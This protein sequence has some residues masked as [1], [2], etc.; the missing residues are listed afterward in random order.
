MCVYGCRCAFMGVDVC[1]GCGCVMYTLLGMYVC[2]SV[3]VCTCV[4]RTCS[5]CCGM[6]PI[7]VAAISS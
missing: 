2:A 4:C 7:L 5:I 6:N 1:Y 3:Y